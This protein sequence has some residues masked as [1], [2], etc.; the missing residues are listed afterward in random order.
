MDDIET[1]LSKGI[2]QTYI[3]LADSAKRDKAAYPSPSEYELVFNSQF[4]NVTK[5]E[6]LNVNIPRTDYLVDNTENSLVYAIGHP[7]NIST[8]QSDLTQIRTANI[9]PGDYNLS[10]LI[11]EIN[12]QLQAVANSFGDTTIV[13]A[14]PTTN[15]SEISNKINLSSSGPFTLLNGSI[16]STLGFGDPVNQTVAAATG[17]YSVVPGYTTNYPNGAENAFLS[18]EGNVLGSPSINEFIGVFPP[19]DNTSF[20]PI[21]TGQTLRQFFTAP[22]AGVPT[23]VTAYFNDV[24]TAPFGGYTVNASIKYASNNTTIASGNIVSINSKLTPSISSLLAVTS[25]FVQGQD[26]YV[27]FTPATTTTSSN[28]TSLWFHQPN[29][30]PV[31]GAYMQVNGANVQTGQYFATTVGAGAIGNNLTSPGIVNIRGARYIKIRCKELEQMIYKDRVGEP[32][33]AGIG[34]VNLIGYGYSRETYDF[35]STT[36]QSFF[37]IGKLQKLTFRL[38]RP[39]GSL[40]DANGVDNSFLC[41]LTYRTVPNSSAEKIF[42]GPGKYPLNTHYTG[43]YIEMLQNRWKQEATATYPSHNKATYTGCRPRTG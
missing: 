37:P 12:V 6:I 8:W 43:D 2:D 17:Y 10:Q 39:D 42:D 41:A 5:F 40:Y 36:P 11:D 21:Y 32:S 13:L 38:E 24:G 14:S 33:T 19:G 3:F 34:I 28:C 35:K 31:A 9:T 30:P 20:Y 29:L 4:R 27:E 15:P 16:N 18:V 25:N 22:A 1:I 26:Y 7:T 23:T